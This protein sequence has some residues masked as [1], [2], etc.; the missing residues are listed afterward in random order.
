MDNLVV[1]D[2]S[3]DLI[4][5]LTGEIRRTKERVIRAV[6]TLSRYSGLEVERTICS[7]IEMIEMADR[8]TDVNSSLPD[9]I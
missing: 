8:I 5:E 9:Q 2:N 7:G 4:S 1:T 3:R 6:E